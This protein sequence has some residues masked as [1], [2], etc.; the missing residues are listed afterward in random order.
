[1]KRILVVDDE[2]DIRTVLCARLEAA[3]YETTVATNG[4]GALS[5]ARDWRPDLIILD[6]ML[7]GID[8]FSVCAML[9][10]DQRFTRTPIII[11]SARCL[12]QDKE[13][14]LSLGA[15]RYLRKPFTATELLD[16]VKTLLAE[17]G[18]GN[19]NRRSKAANR[20]CN[21]PIKTPQS[22]R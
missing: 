20:E 16:E 12:P 3:G 9:K 19:G 10:R 6:L 14:G 4:L 22:A 13:T 7:P 17:P 15:D 8:G 2:E 11:L 18:A 1:M 5:R 21:E